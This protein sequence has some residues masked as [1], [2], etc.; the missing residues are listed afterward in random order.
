MSSPN[1][2]ALAAANQVIA[3]QA[4]A[5]ANA[6]IHQAEAAK[7]K[8][9]QPK[10]KRC[11]KLEAFVE[12]GFITFNGGATHHSNSAS[13]TRCRFDFT[14]GTHMASH[15]IRH[16]NTNGGM[17]GFLSGA[18]CNQNQRM[19]ALKFGKRDYKETFTCE[20][21]NQTRQWTPQHYKAHIASCERN[22]GKL[23][24]KQGRGSHS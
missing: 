1:Q 6:L 14:P 12:S 2:E 19:N 15:I 23:R 9:E 21:C 4:S 22:D 24:Y 20:F 18:M 7:A 10:L 13:C 8:G 11:F 5:A 3:D 17:E 16:V